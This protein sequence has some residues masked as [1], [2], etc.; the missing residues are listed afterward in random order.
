VISYVLQDLSP[1]HHCGTVIRSRLADWE[2]GRETFYIPE[3]VREADAVI[4]V[5]G[6]EG[7][8][9]AANWQGSRTSPCCRSRTSAEPHRRSTTRS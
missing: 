4:L 6:F 2:I 1:V 8:F 7:T 5:G 3:Q 9:R